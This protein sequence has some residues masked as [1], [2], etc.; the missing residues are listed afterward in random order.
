MLLKKIIILISFLLLKLFEVRITTVMEIPFPLLN[1]SKD[2]LRTKIG[3]QRPLPSLSPH[4]AMIGSVR[5][6]Q[7][8]NAIFPDKT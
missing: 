5:G 7:K 1:L 3:R 2:K 6:Q 8:R 4:A